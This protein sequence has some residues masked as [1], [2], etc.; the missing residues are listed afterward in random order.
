MKNW[1]EKNLINSGGKI[2]SRKLN[3]KWFYS[4]GYQKEFDYLKV[5]IRI[6]LLRLR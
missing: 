6:Y 5:S 3:Q 1:A 4:N 2:N